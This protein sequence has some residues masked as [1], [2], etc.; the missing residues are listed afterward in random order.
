MLLILLVGDYG[1]KSCRSLAGTE[2]K[3]EMSCLAMDFGLGRPHHYHHR[4]LFS[5]PSDVNMN[6]ECTGAT[7][8]Q[9]S[10]PGVVVPG[11]C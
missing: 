7:T 1:D 9:L 3:T 6:G 11:G 8:K 5:P 4:H 2:L 10:F